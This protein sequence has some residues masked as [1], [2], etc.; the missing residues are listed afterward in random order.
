VSGT[1]AGAAKAKA[2]I[3]ANNPNHFEEI[4]AKGGKKTMAEGAK[5]KGFAYNRDKA[6]EAGRIGGAISRR[7]KSVK[8]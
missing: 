5:P 1:V 4:G 6:V 2:K 8:S 3:L 7:G